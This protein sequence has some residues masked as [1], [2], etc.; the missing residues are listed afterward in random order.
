MVTLDPETNKN[1]I[2]WE[3]EDIENISSYNIYKKS[4]NDFYQI[5]N[6]AYSEI[7]EFVDL[8]SNPDIYSNQYKISVID[9]CGNESIL[10]PFH[11]TMLLTVSQ[12][13]EE[14]T[15]NLDW[16]YYIDESGDYEP[17]WYYIYRGLTPDNLS[18]YDSV[19][20]GNQF[21]DLSSDLDYYYSIRVEKETACAPNGQNK[22]SGGP[23]YHSSS[24]IEDEGV[25]ST[26]INNIN[27]ETLQIYPN[28]VSNEFNIINIPTNNGTQ[29]II[30]Y[31][32]TGKKIYSEY[33]NLDKTQINIRSWEKGIYFISVGGEKIKLI[34]Q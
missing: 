16:N 2:V 27:S 24:N 14:T 21:P 4:G 20:V 25:I 19:N 31:D 8:N 28:P 1:L 9:S 23:Y 5:G 13:T 32:Y 22:A 10:S 17:A 29:T 7:S 30:I 6:V 12:G 18:L 26:S 33:C 11:Q 15:A 34:K 3:K